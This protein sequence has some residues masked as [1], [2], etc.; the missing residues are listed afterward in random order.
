MIVYF[1]PEVMS[2]TLRCAVMFSPTVC[3]ALSGGLGWVCVIIGELVSIHRKAEV[4]AGNLVTNDE[5]WGG[6]GAILMGD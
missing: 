5:G 4:E 6:A 3:L 1:C 2:A